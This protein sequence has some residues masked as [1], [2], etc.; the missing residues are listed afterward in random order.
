MNTH[1]VKN[2]FLATPFFLFT[3]AFAL[4][5]GVYML[6]TT[7]LAGYYLIAYGVLVLC[8]FKGVEFDSSRKKHRFYLSILG[9]KI[10]KWKNLEPYTAV[11][12]LSRR[13]TFALI[14]FD[15]MF[16]TSYI[17]KHTISR[18]TEYDLVLLSANHRQKKTIKTF[19]SKQKS[20]K[21]ASDIARWTGLKIET[22]N[23]T[24]SARSLQNRRK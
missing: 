21:T 23:P 1:C 10:G 22:Y 19:Y 5:Y 16:G 7:N 11:S 2:G 12:I 9:L 24:I 18:H 6:Y 20:Y 14:P 15:S 8:F 4:I 3:S 17:Y 13:R